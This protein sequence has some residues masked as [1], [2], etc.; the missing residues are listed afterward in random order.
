[1][2][3]IS[4]VPGSW[5]RRLHKAIEFRCQSLDFALKTESAGGCP[6]EQFPHVLSKLVFQLVLIRKDSYICLRICHREHSLKERRYDVLPYQQLENVCQS[7]AKVPI[8]PSVVS[9]HEI[10]AI[11]LTL[12]TLNKTIQRS[13]CN[14]TRRAP[15]STV[16]QR[17]RG[18]LFSGQ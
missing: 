14:I 11:L 8:L 3:L 9:G 6:G 10:M 2:V 15:H 7:P 13:P 1:M 5:T 12:I 16:S 4:T 18:L 17:T